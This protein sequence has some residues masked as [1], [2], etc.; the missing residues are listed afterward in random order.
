MS[1]EEKTAELT[2]KLPEKTYE[3]GPDTLVRRRCAKDVFELGVI[4][5]GFGRSLDDYSEASSAFGEREAKTCGLRE[6]R[7][8]FSQE[9]GPEKKLLSNFE[10]FPGEQQEVEFVGWKLAI[11]VWLLDNEKWRKQRACIVALHGMSAVFGQ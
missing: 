1:I 6:Q 9:T 7:F 8:Q 11:S 3:C 4:G 5:R 10:L 2:P